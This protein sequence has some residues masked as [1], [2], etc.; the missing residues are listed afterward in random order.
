MVASKVGEDRPLSSF[1]LTD[2]S[3]NCLTFVDI[4][5]SWPAQFAPDSRPIRAQ[6][7]PNSRT[8]RAQFSPNS[9]PI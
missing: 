7:A 9:C 5:V 4:V 1:Q 8:G 3:D 6:F 2:Y